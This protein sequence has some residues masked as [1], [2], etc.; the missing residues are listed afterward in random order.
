MS[1]KFMIIVPDKE[2]EIPS[3]IDIIIKRFSKKSG[4]SK[5]NRKIL[6]VVGAGIHQ[7][8]NVLLYRDKNQLAMMDVKLPKGEV[9]IYTMK[10]IFLFL[11][12][13]YR[14]AKTSPRIEGINDHL[15]ILFDII[16][17]TPKK[18][19]LGNGWLFQN[20]EKGSISYHSPYSSFFSLLR[21][22]GI[23]IDGDKTKNLCILR[24]IPE[25]KIYVY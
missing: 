15:K 21:S 18:K 20:W 12:K 11:H 17:F 2:E 14:N 10:E 8:Y 1:K 22:K 7:S 16:R 9:A 24:F 5:E 23:K 13:W 6:P 19:K 3:E 4:F 25:Q